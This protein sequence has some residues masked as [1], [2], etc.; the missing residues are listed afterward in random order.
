MGVGRVTLHAA[1]GYDPAMLLLWSALVSSLS[2]AHACSPEA[3]GIN[4]LL[5][6]A[7]A[8]NVPLD[9]MLVAVVAGPVTLDCAVDVID[10]SGEVI[11]GEVGTGCEG[12]CCTF[13]PDA[14]LLPSATYRVSWFG[15]LENESA[16]TTETTFTTGTDFAAG[17]QA[18]ELAVGFVDTDPV[19]S[20]CEDGDEWSYPVSMLGENSRQHYY[21]V[22][23]DG[24]EI[25]A[26]FLLTGGDSWD[27]EVFLPPGA[28]EEDVT[29]FVA[30]AV[31]AAGRASPWTDPACPPTSGG[32]IG[33]GCAGVPDGAASLPLLTLGALALMRRRRA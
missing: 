31:D 4:P 33:C 15:G 17:A 29:C 14:P 24:G 18:P 21:E 13:T 11:G 5:P 30:R 16:V 26:R 10:P 8:S 20:T 9:A 22:A 23:V 7:A 25:V 3:G 32:T 6:E 27:R 28:S 19:Y 2:T 12:T 1:F